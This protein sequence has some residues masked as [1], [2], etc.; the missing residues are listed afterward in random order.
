M[1]HKHYNKASLL[2]Q[3]IESSLMALKMELLE[4]DGDESDE[5]DNN[6]K[7]C[8]KLEDLISTSIDEYEPDYYEEND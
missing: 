4:L 7:T 2:I 1:K 6:E 3:S 8:F 5:S